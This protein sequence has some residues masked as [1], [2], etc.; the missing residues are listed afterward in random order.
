MT[1]KTGPVNSIV[2]VMRGCWDLPADCND[3]ELFTYA[4]I[5]FDRIQAGREQGCALLVP[6]R[7]AGRQ[8]G[9]A[10]VWSPKIV[11]RSVALMKN[12]TDALPRQ[13]LAARRKAIVAL[14]A[15]PDGGYKRGAFPDHN[16][17]DPRAHGR[18]AHLLD[19][20]A[21]RNAAQPDRRRQRDRDHRASHRRA[22]ARADDARRKPR[23][24][25]ACTTSGRSSAS[26]SNS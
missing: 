1:D 2:A 6:R 3:G 22:E 10:E 9:N 26:S 13:L 14:P 19:P 15:F 24:S 7:R 17:F 8:I 12:P 5:L 18:P 21:R 16:G 11:D 23:R 4:E 25:T 20:Q